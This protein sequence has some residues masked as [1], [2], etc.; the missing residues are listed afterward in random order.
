MAPLGRGRS[1]VV[2]SYPMSRP[3]A[4]LV[5]SEQESVGVRTKDTNSS[6]RSRQKAEYRVAYRYL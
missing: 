4:S 1:L 2:L 6:P 3:L 5:Q